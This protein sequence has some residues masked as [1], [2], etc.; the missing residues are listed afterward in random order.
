MKTGK[1]NLMCNTKETKNNTKFMKLFLVYYILMSI[2]LPI[3]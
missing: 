2:M 3:L 1:E